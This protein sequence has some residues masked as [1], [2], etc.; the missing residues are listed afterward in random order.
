M[1]VTIVHDQIGT[2]VVS[3]GP[4]DRRYRVSFTTHFSDDELLSAARIGTTMVY[5]DPPCF[6][7]GFIVP[8]EQRLTVDSFTKRR[9]NIRRFATSAQAAA[10]EQELR[11]T[12]I[13]HFE[14]LV[15]GAQWLTSKL[16]QTANGRSLPSLSLPQAGNA[17]RP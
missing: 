3:H 17:V 7:R 1:Q 12:I 4:R 11:S 8:I 6:I 2:K 14:R 9:P 16:Q 10:F 13:P 15:Y 5:Q